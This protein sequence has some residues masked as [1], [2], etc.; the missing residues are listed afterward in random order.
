MTQ[1]IIEQA[2]SL[3]VRGGSLT[4]KILVAQRDWDAVWEMA[5]S[6]IDGMHGTNTLQENDWNYILSEA[7][8]DGYSKATTVRQ[9]DDGSFNNIACPDCYAIVEPADQ[10]GCC[11]FCGNAKGKKIYY[12]WMELEKDKG[13]I[14]QLC[15]DIAQLEEDPQLEYSPE[16]NHATGQE[17][18]DINF[19]TVGRL[20]ETTRKDLENRKGVL[21]VGFN[22]EKKLD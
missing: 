20:D 2:K 10:G 19:S 11:P 4:F 7:A 17:Y 1:D 12:H 5:S 16:H 6:Q 22:E 18:Y 13:D 8:K 9:N 21:N 14:G 3:P 15:Q